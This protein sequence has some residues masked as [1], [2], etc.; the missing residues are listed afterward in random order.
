MEKEEEWEI[1]IMKTA[2]TPSHL[3]WKLETR[4][5]FERFLQIFYISLGQALKAGKFSNIMKTFEI[6]YFS[7]RI[8]V[9]CFLECIV[10]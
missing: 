6:R 2:P 5:T 4:L 10:F 7:Y 1:A 3:F 8:I 9:F